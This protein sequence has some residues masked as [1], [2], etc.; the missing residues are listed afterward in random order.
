MPTDWCILGA[1]E[2]DWFILVVLAKLL[3]TSTQGQPPFFYSH[4]LVRS[5]HTH[6]VGGM[7]LE[8][9][10][11]LLVEGA[12]LGEGGVNAARPVRSLD[13]QGVVI[14]AVPVVAVEVGRSRHL[15]SFTFVYLY[16]FHVYTC[17]NH[18]AV[19]TINTLF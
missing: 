16:T 14:F 4:V 11:E 5:L 17:Y 15:S 13:L 18:N 3:A 10:E 6:I 1:M 9:E 12:L 7:G 8:A 19:P 2:G